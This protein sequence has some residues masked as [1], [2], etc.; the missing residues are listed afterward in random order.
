MQQADITAENDF[1]LYDAGGQPLSDR[2]A[3]EQL[4]GFL[5]LKPPAISEVRPMKDGK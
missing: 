2:H 4:L 5:L 1:D 3:E